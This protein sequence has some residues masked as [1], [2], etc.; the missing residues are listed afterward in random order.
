[1]PSPF[2][3]LVEKVETDVLQANNQDVREVLKVIDQI[4]NLQLRYS[5]Q[6]TPQLRRDWARWLTNI[7]ISWFKKPPILENVGDELTRDEV[8]DRVVSLVAALSTIGGASNGCREITIG[9]LNLSVAE[10]TFTES[11]FG[12]QSWGS[13]L[14]L[15]QYEVF[16]RKQ[17]KICRPMQYKM[18]RQDLTS[19]M[20]WH[21]VLLLQAFVMSGF[22]EF[23][24]PGYTW[25][26]LYALDFSKN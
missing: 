15:A 10:S 16:C 2:L 14:I 12:Y 22:A 1:M 26:C 6:I 11:G 8:D 13:S 21:T 17:L 25:F 7:Q 19:C 3:D 23:L 24:H 5:S 9:D 4:E 18:L 20:M